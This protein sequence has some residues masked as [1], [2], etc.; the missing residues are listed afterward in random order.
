MRIDEF[1][2]EEEDKKKRENVLEAKRNR[3]TR[4]T[5]LSTSRKREKFTPSPVSMAFK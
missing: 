4:P 1:E 2:R 3:F 5:E